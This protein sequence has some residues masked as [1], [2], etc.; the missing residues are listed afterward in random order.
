MHVCLSPWSSRNVIN[1]AGFFGL[2]FTLT[3]STVARRVVPNSICV[4]VVSLIGFF[5]VLPPEA[6]EHDQRDQSDQAK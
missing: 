3:S 6:N 4:C 5:Q 2:N 1:V